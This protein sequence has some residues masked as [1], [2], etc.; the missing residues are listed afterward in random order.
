MAS[1]YRSSDGEKAIQAI[2]S[3]AVKRLAFPC[4]DRFINTRFGTTHLLVA[5]P[6]TASPLV[7]VHGGMHPIRSRCP[8][9]SL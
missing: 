6:R 2:Y 3:K 7:I 5:G 8:G 4:E 1:I 9:L